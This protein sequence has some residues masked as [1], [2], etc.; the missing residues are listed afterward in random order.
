MLDPV[1]TS[2]IARA[3]A[4]DHRSFERLVARWDGELLNLAYRLT[5][6]LDDAHDIRQAAYVRAYRGIERFDGRSRFST[7]LFRIVVNLCRDHQRRRRS[8][9]RRLLAITPRSGARDVSAPA[10]GSA[11]RSELADQVRAAVMA[12]T[13][14]QREVLVLRHYHQLSPADIARVL[15]TPVTTVRS[16]LSQALDHLRRRLISATPM[17]S[18][19][20]T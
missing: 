12:L 8:D 6:S 5:G 9:R 3:V 17:S 13:P 11:E 19:R 4:G 16:R 18:T 14:P 15:G 10:D 20:A 2:V 7:W 1:E